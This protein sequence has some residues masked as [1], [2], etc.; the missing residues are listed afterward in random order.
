GLLVRWISPIATRVKDAA[1]DR[2]LRNHDERI[3]QLVK[4]S[5]AVSGDAVT[6]HGN[7]TGREDDDH[8][9]YL[10]IDGSRAMTGE[11]YHGDRTIVLPTSSGLHF[12]SAG[13]H[14]PNELTASFDFY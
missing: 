11:L 7:L 6:D 13:A 12:T 14:V 9:Q 10:P 1:V 4:R 8:P 2:I 3:R 5:D